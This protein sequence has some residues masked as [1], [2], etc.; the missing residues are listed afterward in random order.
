MTRCL[1]CRIVAKELSSNVAYEDDQVLAFHDIHPQ[2]PVHF[3]LIPKKHF[4]S[5][6]AIGDSDLPL[7]THLMELIPKLAKEHGALGGKVMGAGGG[8]FFMFY[9]DNGDKARLRQ[10]L[11]AQGLKELRFLIE[12]EGS[13]VLINL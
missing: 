1:F 7:L 8:G 13:K 6:L 5:M 9:C 2:A 4:D 10:V 3:L 12:P 11:A